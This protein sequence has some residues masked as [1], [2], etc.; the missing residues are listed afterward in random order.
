M[1]K[2]AENIRKFHEKQ[3][4]QGFTITEE[5][6]V[7]LGQKIIPIERAGLYIPGGAQAIKPAFL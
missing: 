4:R 1:L 6:G 3:V 5:N 7:I 2:A